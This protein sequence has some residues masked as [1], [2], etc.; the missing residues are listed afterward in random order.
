[1][2]SHSNRL[3]SNNDHWN[4]I[5]LSLRELI[6]WVIR[7]NTELT[8]LGQ[9]TIQGD[10]ASL[11]KHSVSYFYVKHKPAIGLPP[12]VLCTYTLLSLFPETLMNFGMSP[13]VGPVIV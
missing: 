8:T 7:K 2:L 1:M 11:Q 5:L 3:E 12:L 6:E 4:G 9:S 10:A 13:L